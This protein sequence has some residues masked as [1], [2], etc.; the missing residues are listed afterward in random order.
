VHACEPFLETHKL[1]RPRGVRGPS[2][3]APKG[4]HNLCP[5]CRTCILAKRKDT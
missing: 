4:R 5:L 2:P 3:V 1:P